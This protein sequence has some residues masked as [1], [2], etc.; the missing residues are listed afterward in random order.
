MNN[1][2]LISSDVINTI[3]SLPADQQFSIVS[4]LAGEMIFGAVVGDELSDEEKRL[5]AV[6]KSAVCRDSM[7]HR[8]QSSK[9]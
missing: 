8:C 4:A 2:I 5:Y 6:I 3:R 9:V 7:P 1:S